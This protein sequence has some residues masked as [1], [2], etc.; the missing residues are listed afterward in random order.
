[1]DNDASY[2]TRDPWPTQAW[3]P[4]PAPD[5]S[6]LRRARAELTRCLRLLV[7]LFPDPEFSQTSPEVCLERYAPLPEQCFSPAGHRVTLYSRD[8]CR[9]VEEVLTVLLHK[10]VHLANAFRWIKDCNWRSRHNCRFRQLAQKVGLDVSWVD[11]RYGWA[12]TTPTPTLQW[13]LP[14][15]RLAEEV[16]EPFR[17]LSAKPR[18]M[19]WHCGQFRFPEPEELS[20]ILG[21]PPTP[22]PLRSRVVVRAMTVNRVWRDTYSAPMLRLTGRWLT[23]YG[24][25]QASRVRIDA[26]YGELR[27][28]SR[29]C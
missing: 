6:A 1:M 9:P 29:D 27:I 5:P 3:D 13:F 10:A 7:E 26:R 23:R 15:L 8:L 12:Q 2:G 24:F 18:S 25:P 4:N 16:L 17:D 28:R 14:R 22:S 11:A 19:I 20:A 21:R